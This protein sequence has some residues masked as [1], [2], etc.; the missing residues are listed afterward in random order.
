MYQTLYLLRNKYCF[1]GYIHVKAIP[2]APDELLEQAGYLADRMSINLE[3]PTA[4]GLSMLAPQ[5]TR[6][7]ILTPMRSMRSESADIGLLLGKVLPW[8]VIG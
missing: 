3:L 5:K 4:E 2:H 7:S 6:A 1:N 8:I